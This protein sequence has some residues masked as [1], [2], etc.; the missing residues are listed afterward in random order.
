MLLRYQEK[1]FRIFHNVYLNLTPLLLSY[2]I[3]LI[4]IIFYS[5]YKISCPVYVPGVS[6]Q[7]PLN[8]YFVAYSGV[9]QIFSLEI[10]RLRYTQFILIRYTFYS[11]ISWLPLSDYLSLS[12]FSFYTKTTLIDEI[13]RRSVTSSFLFRL[14]EWSQT[15][16]SNRCINTGL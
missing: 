4:Y 8:F 10:E 3:L 7:S 1:I 14:K 15:Q 13:K 5:I 6:S 12:L 11:C 9:K 2:S 16:T